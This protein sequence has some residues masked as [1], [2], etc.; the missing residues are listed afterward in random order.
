MRLR[1]RL[2][3]LHDIVKVPC[4]ATSGVR[5]GR[6]WNGP[7]V[8]DSAPCHRRGFGIEVTEIILDLT[9]DQARWR[10]PASRYLGD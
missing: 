7:S 2:P 9:A 3:E 5:Y 1:R 4:V 8:G 10:L 6:T